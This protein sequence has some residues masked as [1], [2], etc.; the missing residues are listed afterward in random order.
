MVAIVGQVAMAQNSSGNILSGEVRAKVLKR[1]SGTATLPKPEN[2]VIHDFAVPVGATQTDESPA[3]RLHRDIKLRHGLQ[4]DSS[5]E[6]LARQVQVAFAKSLVGEVEKVN[7][8]TVNVPVREGSPA[9][10]TAPGSHLVID[11]KFDAINEGDETKR[12]LIGLGRGASD[13]KAHVTVSSVTQGH[14]TTVL[15]LDLS[16]K[17][18][19]KPGAAAGMGSVAVGA[20]AGGVSDRKSTVEADASR[21]AKL[22]AKQ[23]EAFMA[24]QKWISNPPKATG[25]REMT[26]ADREVIQGEYRLEG[27]VPSITS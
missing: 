14:K 5:P 19:K 10:N 3:G 1:Y 13:I 11:G 27:L 6:V 21:M 25:N 4:E 9:E 8:P 20:A 26:R 16:S 12:L 24:D 18:G 7:I 2:V 23:V 22:V 15:E 17:S